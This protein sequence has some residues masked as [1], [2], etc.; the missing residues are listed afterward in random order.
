MTKSVITSH[1][2]ELVGVESPMDKTPT[3]F[4]KNLNIFLHIILATQV[5]SGGEVLL[6]TISNPSHQFLIIHQKKL[7]YFL[8]LYM[9][10]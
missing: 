9:S 7:K 8:F 2:S 6:K 5:T 1:L 10:N 3:S 4:R